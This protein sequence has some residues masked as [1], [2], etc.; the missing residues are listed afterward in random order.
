MINF[1]TQYFTLKLAK[2]FAKDTCLKLVKEF[3][4]ALLK[5]LDTDDDVI[6][7]IKKL[8]NDDPDDDG[9]D[10]LERLVSNIPD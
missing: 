3:K 9:N 10:D 1:L 6:G 7:E 4:A 5:K 2:E 8:S